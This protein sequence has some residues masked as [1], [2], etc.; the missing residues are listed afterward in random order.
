MGGAVA[1]IRSGFMQKEIQD[2]A[3]KYQKAVESGEITVVCVNKFQSETGKEPE[4]LLRVDPKLQ[5]ERAR[6]LADLRKKRDNAKV[7]NS[8]GAVKEAAR[9]NDNLMPLFVDAVENYTTLGEICSVL[10]DVFGEYRET[11][12]Y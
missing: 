11:E 7:K 12:F 2:S 10:V 3:Y 1:A 9:G 8:L 4:W 6:E 5:E